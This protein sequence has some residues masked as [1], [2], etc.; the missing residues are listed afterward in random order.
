MKLRIHA[1]QATG[2]A[3]APPLRFGQ[4]SDVQRTHLGTLGHL[5][6]NAQQLRFHIGDV[7]AVRGQ[8]TASGGRRERHAHLQFRIVAAASAIER[9]RPAAVKDVFAA[10][11]RFHVHGHDANRVFDLVSFAEYHMERLP[12]GLGT[13]AAARFQGMQKAMVEKRVVFRAGRVGATVPCLR[14]DGGDVVQNSGDA[15]RQNT[16]RRR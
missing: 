10:G 7:V 3:S 6:R 13:N 1:L 11:V 2:I 8:Q 15:L 16:A 14:I 4:K 12:T 5:H 9:F